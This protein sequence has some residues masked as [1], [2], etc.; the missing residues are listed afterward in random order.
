MKIDEEHEWQ[1][2]L[3]LEVKAGEN[4]DWKINV[5]RIQLCLFKVILCSFGY[6]YFTHKKK[7]SCRSIKIKK[8]I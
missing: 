3:T 4:K 8:E 5:Y 1:I 2:W 6:M 7:K